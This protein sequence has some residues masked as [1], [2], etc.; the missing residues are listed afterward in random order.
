MVKWNMKIEKK[1]F[2]DLEDNIELIIRKRQKHPVQ[3]QK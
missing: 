1:L 2:L 3:P